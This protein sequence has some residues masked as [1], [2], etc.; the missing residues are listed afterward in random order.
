[1]HIIIIF[2]QM[3]LQELSGFS[4]DKLKKPDIVPQVPISVVLFTLGTRVLAQRYIH[5]LFPSPI[6]IIIQTGFSMR[7]D[8]SCLCARPF[9]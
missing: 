9:Q 4:P 5:N 2:S 8:L 6:I 7:M 3:Q 1:M